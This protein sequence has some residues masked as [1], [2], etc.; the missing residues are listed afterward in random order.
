[1]TATPLTNSHTLSLHDALPIFAFHV[2]GANQLWRRTESGHFVPEQ[3]LVTRRGFAL[4][5]ERAPG[6]MIETT[7]G[8][9]LNA[10]TVRVIGPRRSEEHT[11]ELQSRENL[12]CRLLL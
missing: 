6:N 5:G 7:T 8:L 12:V 10:S 3:Q 2:K 4:T 9:W 11:S 1:T